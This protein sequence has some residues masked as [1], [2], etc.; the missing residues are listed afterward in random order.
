MQCEFHHFRRRRRY[1]CDENNTW[2][3]MEL[4]EGAKVV[5]VKWAF[6]TKLNE[7]GDVDKFKARIVAKGYHQKHVVDFHEMF[8]PL[9]RW[10]T[11]RMLLALHAEKA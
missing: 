7:K 11:V 3:L 4:Q 2:E 8:A 10:D 5:G 6:K 9:A 1:I